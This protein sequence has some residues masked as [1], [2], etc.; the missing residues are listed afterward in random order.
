MV[1]ISKK[2]AKVNRENC[3]ACGSCMKECPKAA[4]S[5]YRGCYAVVNELLCIGCG[6]CARICPSSCIAAV[7]REV[8]KA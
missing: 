3:V 4:I 6:K 2:Y 5:I 1:M 7:E 8:A